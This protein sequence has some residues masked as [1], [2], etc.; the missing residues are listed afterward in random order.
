MFILFNSDAPLSQFDAFNA[1]AKTEDFDAEE[2]GDLL[3]RFGLT[4]VQPSGNL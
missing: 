3:R 4:S 2:V 1:R